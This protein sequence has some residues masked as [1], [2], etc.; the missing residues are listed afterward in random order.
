MKSEKLFLKNWNFILVLK[1]IWKERIV[2]KRLEIFLDIFGKNLTS[3]C[4]PLPP[5]GWQS[6]VIYERSRFEKTPPFRCFFKE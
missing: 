3:D 6:D 4:H 2:P 1:T 5:G